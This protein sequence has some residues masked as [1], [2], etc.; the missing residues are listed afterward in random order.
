MNGKKYFL[1]LLLLLCLKVA[2][3]KEKSDKICY[4]F[5]RSERV[6][7]NKAKEINRPAKTSRAQ[8][9]IRPQRTFEPMNGNQARQHDGSQKRMGNIFKAVMFHQCYSNPVSC[10]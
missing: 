2:L 1:S 7:E 3:T 6:V 8:N 5:P 9:L 10:F 4:L